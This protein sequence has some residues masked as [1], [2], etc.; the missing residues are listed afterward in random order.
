M[1]LHN[2][3]A[4]RLLTQ[5]EVTDN[6]GKNTKDFTELDD[7]YAIRKGKLY[8]ND[9]WPG[10]VILVPFQDVV[11]DLSDVTRMLNA[12]IS[13]RVID[14]DLDAAYELANACCWNAQEPNELAAG[15]DGW[16]DPTQGIRSM[17]LRRIEETEQ[18]FDDST[19]RMRFHVEYHFAAEWNLTA[20]P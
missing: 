4:S 8:A 18:P 11:S 10:I 19:D 15:L 2:I 16:S 9:P 6:V 1:R 12:E 5:S 7:Q 14:T 20:E 13:V 3:I 17:G